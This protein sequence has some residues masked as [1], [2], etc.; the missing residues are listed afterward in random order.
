MTL[1]KN[2]RRKRNAADM[3]DRSVFTHALTGESLVL[4]SVCGAAINY[5]SKNNAG[6]I[7]LKC[8]K[9][10]PSQPK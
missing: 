3:R 1:S 5:V 7:E 4:C 6:A 8:D 10:G 9:C 2:Q